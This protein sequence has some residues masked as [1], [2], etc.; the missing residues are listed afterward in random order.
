MNFE[1]IRFQFTHQERVARIT[2][3][4][5][6]ANILD[7]SMILELDSA[8]SLCAGRELNALVIAADGPHFS[9]GAS[10]EEHLPDQ[11]AGTL[12]A[13]NALLR[14]IADA[15]APVIAAVRGQCLGGGFE[16]VL[17]CDLILADKTAQF[18]SPEIKLAVFAPAASALLPVR[19]GLAIASRLLLTGAALSAEEAARFGL[20]ARCAD[21]LDG[22][23]ETWL[24]SD[25]LPRSPSALKYACQ[26]ARRPLR[27][28][29]DEDLPQIESLYLNDLMATP[30]AVEGIRAFLEKRAPQFA[31]S[32]IMTTGMK[33]M[34]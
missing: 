23:L 18:G 15:P 32:R 20:V 13:L 30:D 7:R 29:L 8:L 27:R 19:I 17:A 9:F 34:K 1:K 21:D 26:A 24:E 12:R 22:A 10:V 5:P 2:L 11:I 3:A 16:L 4:A 33:G 28:A 14:R 6:K 25:F 31:R